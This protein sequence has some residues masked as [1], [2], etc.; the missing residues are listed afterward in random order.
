[1]RHFEL[2]KPGDS[3]ATRSSITLMGKTMPGSSEWKLGIIHPF[4]EVIKSILL[5]PKTTKGGLGDY[6]SIAGLWEWFLH[7]TS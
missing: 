7:Q 6:G 3:F 1:M 5:T 2:V 4:F